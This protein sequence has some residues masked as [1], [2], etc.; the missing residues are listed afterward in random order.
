MRLDA[1]AGHSLH[2]SL[3][4]LDTE[5]LPPNGAL[6]GALELIHVRHWKGSTRDGGPEGSEELLRLLSNS[7]KIAS[8]AQSSLA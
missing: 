7:I 2:A 6:V 1:Q 5:R 3:P 8:R 4:I